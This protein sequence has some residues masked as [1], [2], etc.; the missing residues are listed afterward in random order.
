[1]WADDLDALDV[2]TQFIPEPV[3]ISMLMFGL[4]G[5]VRRRR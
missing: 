1:M 3:G 2:T 4:I 5:W